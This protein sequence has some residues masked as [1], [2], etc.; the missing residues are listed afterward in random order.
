MAQV[1]NRVSRIK[2]KVE[3]LDS[4][5][6]LKILRKNEWNVQDLWDTIKTPKLQ[7][8]GLSRNKQGRNIQ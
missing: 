5:G 7:V 3:E 8:I 6:K 1:E 4:S 2:D